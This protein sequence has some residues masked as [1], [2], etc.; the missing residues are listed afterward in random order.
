MAEKKFIIEVRTKGFTRATKNV[1][2]LDKDTQS[3]N[4]AANRM[5]G[6]TQGLMANLGSLRNKILV[7]TFALGGAVAIMNKFVKA[8]SGFQDVKTRLVGLTGSV[9][10]AKSAF[11]AFN[12]V[13][14]TTPFAL[15]DVV[16]AGAQLQAFGLDAKLTLRATTDLAAFMGTTATEAAS[17]LGRAF[18]GGVGAADMLRDK[19][20]RQIIADSQGITDITKITLPEFRVALIKAMTDPDGRISGSA[21]RLSKTFSGAVTNMQDA[22]T[23]FAAQIGDSVLGP[24]T[25]VVNKTESFFRALDPKRTAEVATSI[26]A[27]A[28][29]FGILKI[30]A[31]LANAAFASYGKIAKGIVLAGTL[32]GIDKLF[33]FAGTFE[34]LETAVDDSSD[35]LNNQSNELDA[36]LAKIGLA[37]T[38]I[39]NMAERVEAFQ[40]AN[41]SLLTGYE[42]QV[43]A[44]LA[45]E[46]A[47]DGKSLVEQE[48]IKNMG[49]MTPEMKKAIEQIEIITERINAQKI[50]QE[51]ANKIQKTKLELLDAELKARKEFEALKEEI[52][53]DTFKKAQEEL[54]ELTKASGKELAKNMDESVTSANEFANGIILA[55]GAMKTLRNES[56]TVEQKM[57]TLLATLGS[58]L[59][60]TPGGQI[61]GALLTAGSMFVG[62][63]GGLIKQNGIQRFAQGGQV[64]GEDNVP[65][66][67]QAGEFIMKRSAVQNIGVQNLANMNR[68]GSSGGV[69]IN[70]SGNM[71]GNDEFVRDNLI[72]EIQKV[73]NQ[74]LA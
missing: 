63:T 59:M 4:K 72:P 40:K 47:L 26:G 66:M 49:I 30:Q 23:R 15:Q 13:A 14:A 24:L 29:A 33:Q 34:H 54:K 2:N 71:I 12:K 28:T 44:L 56:A 52:R 73:S 36:Y 70:I 37:D 45:Q 64:Q 32:L 41:K 18:A 17:A 74:G 21:D 43:A 9:E 11:I 3:Y 60:M 7:Y 25:E 62:H 16:N 53:Q 5:R 8:A 10:E 57:A 67:A 65:I 55:A 69:T 27:L 1:K 38:A 50:A 42:D 46:A 35:S 68:T 20:I 39:N 19:G 31:I 6:E 58:V 22:M 51:K 61:P 48:T